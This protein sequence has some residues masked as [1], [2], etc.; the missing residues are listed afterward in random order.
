[1]E[2][3]KA[4]SLAPTVVVFFLSGSANL[5]RGGHWYVREAKEREEMQIILDKFRRYR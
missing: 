4:T 3:E 2:V 5:N 1:M